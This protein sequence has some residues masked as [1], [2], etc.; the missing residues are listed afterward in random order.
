MG[1]RSDKRC[2]LISAFGYAGFSIGSPII[3]LLAN[4][5]PLDRAL[6]TVALLVLLVAFL[7]PAVR[8]RGALTSG[9]RRGQ[10]FKSLIGS[11][12]SGEMSS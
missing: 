1:H 4:V 3:G 6:L 2:C 10:S 5:V 12:E 7:A 9:G 11:R 8:E